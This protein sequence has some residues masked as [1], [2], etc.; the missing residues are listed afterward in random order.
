MCAT[1]TTPTTC[2]TITTTTTTTPLLRRAPCYYCYH[3]YHYMYH[4]HYYAT[5]TTTTTTTPTTTT[6]TTTATTPVTH[7]PAVPRLLQPAGAHGP[8]ARGDAR[9]P[10]A[11]L[12]RRTDTTEGGQAHLAA[13]VRHGK[14]HGL[15]GPSHTPPVVRVCRHQRGTSGRQDVEGDGKR[16]ASGAESRGV[17]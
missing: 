15:R 12:P 5:T 1:T 14:P 4:Y 16:G 3:Y 7:S 13:A 6:T 10:S 17:P 9:S 2:A 11:A 8:A